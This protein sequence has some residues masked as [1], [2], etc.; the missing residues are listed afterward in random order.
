MIKV[1]KDD[2]LHESMYY[3]ELKNG[4]EIYV[5]PKRGYSKQIAIYAT[6]YGSNDISFVVPGE[7]SY[8]SSIRYCSFLRA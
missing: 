3:K 1:I 7:K 4:L 6:K 8:Y 2:I 5:L